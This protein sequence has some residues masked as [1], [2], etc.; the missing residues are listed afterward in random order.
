MSL[1]NERIDVRSTNGG[2]PAFFA[3]RGGTYR[4]RRVIGTWTSPG[5]PGPGGGH[6]TATDVQLIRVA[7]ESDRGE[8]SVA[9][10]TRDPATDDWTLRRIWD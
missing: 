6:A 1:Y 4:V 2:H 9:D 10:I 5:D 7:A 8:P 3:W